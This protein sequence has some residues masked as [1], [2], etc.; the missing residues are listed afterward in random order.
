MILVVVV[1][2]IMMIV[3]LMPRRFVVIVVSPDKASRQ[4]HG[5]C[6]QQ[7][8]QFQSWPC[9]SLHRVSS[10]NDETAWSPKG[11]EVRINGELHQGFCPGLGAS[12]VNTLD[13]AAKRQRLLL[14]IVF[15]GSTI[16]RNEA[17]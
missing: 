8:R 7:D 6:A 16:G 4:Q 10:G 12:A 5:D 15:R 17:Q 2:L 14:E 13:Q 3:I 11:N 9:G 1:I